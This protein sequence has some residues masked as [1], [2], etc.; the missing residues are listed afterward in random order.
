[1]ARGAAT[2]VPTPPSPRAL[3]ALPSEQ[4]HGRTWTGQG[5]QTH[6]NNPLPFSSPR[7]AGCGMITDPNQG[8]AQLLL[9]THSKC[10][11]KGH[12]GRAIL[13]VPPLCQ[14]LSTDNGREG[15]TCTCS[16]PCCVTCATTT[17]AAWASLKLYKGAAPL[18]APSAH[19]MAKRGLLGSIPGVPWEQSHSPGR[20]WIEPQRLETGGQPALCPLWWFLSR[21]TGCLPAFVRSTKRGNSVPSRIA[22]QAA[23]AAAAAATC[24]PLRATIG[25]SGAGTQGFCGLGKGPQHPPCTDVPSPCGMPLWFA[26]FSPRSL[27][28]RMGAARCREQEVAAERLLAPDSD[29]THLP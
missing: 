24:A 3:A 18:G 28:A 16:C 9:M 29:P 13:R 14:G 26:P 2:V 11:H 15:T 4:T 22:N 6:E 23:L 1:M 21:H 19:P 25:S 17:T 12:R 10:C 7:A 8:T 5:P 27:S 20:C